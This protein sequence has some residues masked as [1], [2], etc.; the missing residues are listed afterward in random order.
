MVR[1]K[2][3]ELY[4]VHNHGVNLTSRDIYLHSFYSDDGSGYEPG[5]EYRQATTFIKNL[6]ILDDPTH[7]PI[8]IH[9]HSIGG[10]WDNGMA[11]FN[12]I[13]FTKSPITMLAY[14]QA[15]SMSGILFQSGQRRVL[16]PDCHFLMHHGYVPTGDGH[17]FALKNEADRQITACKRMLMIFAE[18]AIVGEFFKKRKSSTVQSAYNFFDK[19]LKKEVDWFL[20]AEETVFYGLADG[21]LGSKGFLDMDSLREG[22]D[23]GQQTIRVKPKRQARQPEQETYRRSHA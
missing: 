18:R 13:Q 23:H 20:S 14:S 7:D 10:C 8:L 2:A 5:V 16:M 19:K 9:L 11:M 15:S 1:D 12:A 21:I 22:T 4:D 6:H 3:Q 17:P